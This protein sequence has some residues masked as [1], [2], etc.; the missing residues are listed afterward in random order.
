MM[1]RAT[2]ESGLRIVRIR[3]RADRNDK[4]MAIAVPIVVATRASISVSMILSQESRAVSLHVHPPVDSRVVKRSC[5][6]TSSGRS[7]SVN[8]MVNVPSGPTVGVIVWRVT[9]EGGMNESGPSS[10]GSKLNPR[11]VTSDPGRAQ[12]GNISM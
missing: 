3:L 7:G 1:N 8:V 2:L 11:T 4:G 6:T 10:P 5:C 12:V 9:P